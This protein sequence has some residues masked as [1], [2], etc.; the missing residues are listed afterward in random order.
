MN[1]WKTTLAGLIGAVAY[2]LA[3]YTGRNDWQ[4]YVGAAAIAALGFMSKD[5][6]THSTV[7]QT[8]TATIQS[9]DAALKAANQ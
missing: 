9:N 3:N 6:N 5:F 1:N 2:A 7:A 8:Q 4:G